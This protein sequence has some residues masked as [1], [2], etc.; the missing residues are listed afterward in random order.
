MTPGTTNLQQAW[1]AILNVANNRPPILS[2]PQ[3]NPIKSN[4]LTITLTKPHTN[5]KLLDSKIQMKNY[6]GFP[7]DR[8]LRRKNEV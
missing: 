2:D 6:I 1:I 5:E 4:G 7:G 3:P 8:S